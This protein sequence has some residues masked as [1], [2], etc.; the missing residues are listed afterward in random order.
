LTSR[1]FFSSRPLP[2][3]SG[4][5]FIPTREERSDYAKLSFGDRIQFHDERRP[6]SFSQRFHVDAAFVGDHDLFGDVEAE[7]GALDVDLV[8][9]PGAGEL[10]EEERQDLR[11]DADAGN[12]EAL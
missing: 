2:H 8:G 10:L 7:T 12:F 3:G 5:F 4:L 9:I 11:V 1:S 6:L